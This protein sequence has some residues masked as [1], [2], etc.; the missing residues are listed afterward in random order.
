MGSTVTIYLDLVKG[1]VAPNSAAKPKRRAAH[2]Q[3]LASNVA[4]D[5]DAREEFPNRRLFCVATT[6]TR[7][8]PRTRTDAEHAGTFRVLF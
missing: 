5:G 7:A 8:T 4:N 3:R 1:G 2:H 6:T